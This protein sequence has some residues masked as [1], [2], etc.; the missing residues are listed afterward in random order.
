MIHWQIDPQIILAVI[1]TVIL[2]NTLISHVSKVGFVIYYVTN[3]MRNT[4]TNC[5]DTPVSSIMHCI[6]HFVE[7]RWL[8]KLNF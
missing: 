5:E 4:F 2:K 3:F 8:S 6:V 7:I 1:L